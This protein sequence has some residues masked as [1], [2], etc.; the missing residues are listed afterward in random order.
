MHFSQRHI[1]LV[2][3]FFSGLFFGF[4]CAKM[5]VEDQS[6][7]NSWWI[8]TRNT[9]FSS[10]SSADTSRISLDVFDSQK[11]QE[12]KKLIEKEYYHFSEKSKED[13]ENGVITGIVW[14]LWDKHSEYFSQKNAKEFSD[15][16]RWDFEGI[17]AVIG[18][19]KKWIIIKKIIDNS[20]AQKSWLKN[21]DILLRVNNENLV[22]LTS[23]EAVEKIRWPKW[24]SITL[25]YLRWDDLKEYSVT[26]LRDTVLVPSIHTEVFSGTGYSGSIWY[27]EVWYFWEH[28]HDDFVHAVQDMY[29]TW[30]KGIILDFRNNPGGYLDSAVDIL[31]LFLEDRSVAVITRD[32]DPRK[33]QT[34]FTK[35]SPQTNTKIPL[36]ILVNELSASASEIFA[37]A[38]QDHERAIILW[39]KTYG[40]WSV[41][42]PFN[43]SDGSILK[44]TVGRWF[45]PKNRWIDHIGITP[46]VSVFFKEE[47]IKNMYDRQLK[48]A[49]TIMQ[50]IL[51]E[52][53]DYTKTIKKAQDLF[54]NTP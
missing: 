26:T 8:E 29:S 52:G 33:N 46:D 16:L 19:H 39:Q 47:D 36:V 28:T 11:I 12:A 20:P 42:V 17:G 25:V 13:I 32:N 24:S 18:E 40:K 37:G 14:S 21:N 23:S 15:T 44:L 38:L 30:A 50:M 7:V 4:F 3:L 51:S 41:Q 34:Y 49:Q 48:S 35:K 53:D 31:S 10:S 5:P 6:I 1:G 22:W 2:F 27:I 45:T 54:T 9:L 43:M